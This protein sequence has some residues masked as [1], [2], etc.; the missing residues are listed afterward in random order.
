MVRRREREWPK[1]HLLGTFR[2]KT[3]GGVMAASGTEAGPMSGSSSHLWGSFQQGSWGCCT[4]AAPHLCRFGLSTPPPHCPHP[5]HCQDAIILTT[6]PYLRIT[7]LYHANCHG[8]HPP[9][10]PLPPA[11]PLPTGAVTFSS[12]PAAETRRRCRCAALIFAP[13][14]PLL[15]SYEE[16]WRGSKGAG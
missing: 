3:A 9:T 8:P 13:H 5:H 7:Y 14:F 15:F 12:Q 6:C 16:R 10:P 1:G 4:G 2:R 11:R